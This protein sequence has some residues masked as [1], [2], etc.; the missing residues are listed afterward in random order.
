MVKVTV[1]NGVVAGIA[2]VNP[3]RRYSPSPTVTVAPPPPNFAYVTYWS[4]DGSGI[5]GNE[6]TQ[7]VPL[8]VSQGVFSVNLGDGQVQN[9]L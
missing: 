1:A 7:A 9:L 3:G 5:A 2:V 6:P 4:N 8:H